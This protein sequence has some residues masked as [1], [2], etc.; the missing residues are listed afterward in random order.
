MVVRQQPTRMRHLGRGLEAILGGSRQAD[1]AVDSGQAGPPPAEGKVTVEQIPIQSITPNPYQARRHWDQEKLAQLAQSIKANGLVQPVLVRRTAAGYQLIAG[2]RRLRAFQLL[3]MTTIP[4]IVRQAD[5]T[6]QL[7]LS[8]LENLQRDDL[9]AIDRARAYQA[10]IRITGYTQSE[11]ARRL[12][13][14]DGVICNYLRLLDLPQDIQQMLIDGAISMGHARALLGLPTDELR[15][16]LANKVVAQ[17]L[18]VREVERLVRRWL[19]EIEPGPRRQH[20]IAAHISDLEAKISAAL[21]TKV[22]IDV[23]RNGRQG[24]LT[25]A[26]QSL[27][28]FDRILQI[29]GVQVDE[30]IGSVSTEQV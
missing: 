27:E 17:Q 13:E 25:I 7:E 21:G 30:R 15:R 9:N 14:D 5:D 16:K 1:G 24:R 10:Y 6:Q 23:N 4:A 20:P 3:G 26:F 28:D 12:G 18:S 19:S 11:A 8:L 29:L 2:E 22:R